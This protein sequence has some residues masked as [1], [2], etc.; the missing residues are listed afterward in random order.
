MSK[1]RRN[2]KAGVTVAVR[3][4]DSFQNASASLGWGTNNQSSASQYALSYQS[5]NRINLE[6]AYRGS[7]V[8]RAAVDAMPE[9]MTRCGI[10]MSGLE[11]EDISL[12]ER[13]MMRLA[14]WDA[15]CDDGKWANLYGGCLAVMLIDGQDFAT[16]LA[17]RDDR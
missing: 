13:D 8:V 9:D 12:I 7:W 6:A 16:P 3:T 1:S 17:R 2:Q 10:E 15:L 14:I 5:R 11:P 4:S